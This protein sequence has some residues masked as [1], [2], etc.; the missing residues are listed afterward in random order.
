[1]TPIAEKSTIEEICERFDADVERFSSLETGQS[2]TMD[3]PL[4]LE[5][6]AQTAATHVPPGG[7]ALDLGCGA[8]NFT[9]RVMQETGPLHC[10]LADLSRP[11]LDRAEARTRG[12]GALGVET[13]QGELRDLHFADETFDCILAGAVLHHLRDDEDWRSVF[14]KLRRWLKPGGRL[15]VADLAIFDS[16]PLQEMMWARYGEY[17]SGLGGESHRDKVFAYI[18]GEDTARSLAWQLEMLRAS[19]FR[20]WEVLHR[21]GVFACYSGEV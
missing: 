17:L 11:M 15:Y 3:A 8:G 19:G 9:L 6:V 2:A 21:I 1:M 13:Y 20:S 18:D 14:A 12:H 4:V 7:T 10:H 5:L 16:P